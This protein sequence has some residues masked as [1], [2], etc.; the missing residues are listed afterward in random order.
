MIEANKDHS[1]HAEGG[2]C[3]P[4]CLMS[5]EYPQGNYCDEGDPAKVACAHCGQEFAVWSD[6]EIVRISGKIISEID[7]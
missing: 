7:D 3:C 6:T 2:Y 5:D 1:N 4:H